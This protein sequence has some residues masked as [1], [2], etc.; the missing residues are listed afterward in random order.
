MLRWRYKE[1]LM[2]IGGN[3]ANVSKRSAKGYVVRRFGR[4][5]LTEWGSII[6]RNR[7][8][9]ARPQWRGKP[10]YKLV[11]YASVKAAVRKVKTILREQRRQGYRNVGGAILPAPKA[12]W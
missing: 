11:E 7:P 10:R 12:K 4:A 9:P 8:A 3:K 5:I 1:N 6:F 2:L